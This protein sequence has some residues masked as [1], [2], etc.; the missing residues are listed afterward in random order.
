MSRTTAEPIE[1]DGYSIPANTNVILA[2]FLL[3]RNPKAGVYNWKHILPCHLWGSLNEKKEKIRKEKG[4]KW[5]CEV[6]L[7]RVQ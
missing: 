7:K 4:S 2:N 6:E 5:I 1:I 3:H